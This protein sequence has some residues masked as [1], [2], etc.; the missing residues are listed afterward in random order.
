MSPFAMLRAPPRFRS[1]QHRCVIRDI[2]AA[3]VHAAHNVLDR[4]GFSLLLSNSEGREDFE[5]ELLVR[6]SSQRSD[7]IKIGP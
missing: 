2:K 4:A 1:A 6:L 5:R 3:F 7:G